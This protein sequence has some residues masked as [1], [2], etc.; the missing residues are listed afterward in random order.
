MAMKGPNETAN[1]EQTIVPKAT[2]RVKLKLLHLTDP[3]E[4]RTTLEHNISEQLQISNPGSLNWTN[5]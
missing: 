2:R 4:N 3:S 5:K 1:T